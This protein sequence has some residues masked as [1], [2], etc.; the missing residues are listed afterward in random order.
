MNMI[1]QLY[2]IILMSS[3]TGCASMQGAPVA[4]GGKTALNA[5]V[6][7]PALAQ[8]RV[9][10]PVDVAPLV[11]NYLAAIISESRGD[12]DGAAVYYAQA[13]VADPEN[14]YLKEKTFS[15]QLGM[16]NMEEAVRLARSLEGYGAPLVPLMQMTLGV[17][18]F[19]VGDLKKARAYMEEAALASPKLLHFKLISAYIDL[20]EGRDVDTVLEEIEGFAHHASLTPRRFYHMGRIL[21]MSGRFDEAIGAYAASQGL[22]PVSVFPTMR[23]GAI[24]RQREEPLKARSVYNSFL[25]MNPSS[26]MLD[27]IIRNFDEGKPAGY[28]RNS[29]K[30]NI[31]EV[32]F[33]F[34]TVMAAQHKGLASYQL[35]NMAMELDPDYDFSSFYYAVLAEQEG[36]LHKALSYYKK[37]DESQ[38]TWL[39]SQMRIAEINFALGKRKEAISLMKK[40]SAQYK[41]TLLVTRALAEMYYS[42]GNYKDSV[43]LYTVLIDALKD[44]DNPAHAWLYFARGASYERLQRFAQ[45][46]V[47]L[48]QSIKIQPNNAVALNYL[49]YMWLDRNEKMDKATEYITRALVLRPQDGAILDS[50]GWLLYKQKNYLSAAK[51]IEKALDYIPDDATVLS[52]LGDIYSALERTEDAHEMWA[53]ALELAGKDVQLRKDLKRK[54]AGLTKAQK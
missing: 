23:M 43:K 51:F 46:E 27:R 29:L 5:S 40:L 45:A 15:L 53:A 32:L 11:S 39:V 12:V 26:L 25:K 2:T 1:K 8:L 21:E 14:V 6:V 50:M 16:G 36:L 4:E 28:L 49:G 37:V 34:S 42:A 19:Q 7:K 30:Q 35:L 54:L 48:E 24:Y 20:E 13:Q 47:D 33:G 22:D 31:A 44:K 10:R 41:D 52:H 18:A 9:D 3:L 38:Q 17:Q